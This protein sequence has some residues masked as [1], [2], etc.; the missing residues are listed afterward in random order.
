MK[1]RH[2][3]VISFYLLVSYKTSAQSTREL[4]GYP[5]LIFNTVFSDDVFHSKKTYSYLNSG[6]K[7]GYEYN[8]YRVRHL[9]LLLLDTLY[10]KNSKVYVKKNNEYWLQFDYE[11]P[12]NIEITV[13]P[14]N[15][16]ENIT[17]KIVS[18]VDTIIDG[19][20]RRKVI[21][22]REDILPDGTWIEGIGP[23]SKNDVFYLPSNLWTNEY[24]TI[25]CVM[26]NQTVIYNREGFYKCDQYCD[27]PLSRFEYELDS[28]IIRIVNTSYDATKYFW[29]FSDGQKSE[30]ISPTLAIQKKCHQ[31]T[32]KTLNHCKDTSI[33]TIKIPVCIDPD[34][35]EDIALPKNY[36]E[37]NIYFKDSLN[38][39]YFTDTLFRTKDGG[40]TWTK[41]IIF[42]N[43]V[44]QKN[45]IKGMS[46]SDASHGIVILTYQQSAN[47]PSLI[48]TQDGGS[49]W[50]EANMNINYLSHPT[51]LASGVWIVQNSSNL[52]YTE[53]FGISW[54]EI[55]IPNAFY[56]PNYR[57]HN[58]NLY[59][60]GYGIYPQG[61]KKYYLIKSKDIGLS[62][63]S[64]TNSPS[65]IT[66][67]HVKDNSDLIFS[68]VDYVIKSNSTFTSLDTLLKISGTWPFIN[69]VNDNVGWAYVSDKRYP[70]QGTIYRTADGGDSWKYENC[71]SIPINYFF[72]VDENTAY[73]KTPGKTLA[74]R[75]PE[76][77]LECRRSGMEKHINISDY[78]SF[79]V[80]DN[81]VHYSNINNE[82]VLLTLHS[83]DG[84]LLLNRYYDQDIHLDTHILSLPK[85]IYITSLRSKKGVIS[86]KFVLH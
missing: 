41:D 7:N 11:A 42:P 57:F 76:R 74:R 33:Y 37:A 28:S 45:R 15:S 47:K 63:E 40:K 5:G 34:W 1:A 58:G 8:V 17:Y 48:Y 26:N 68:T 65:L 69:F 13:R 31:V 24:S 60:F 46:F 85:G 4:Y 35:V 78:T 21:A 75:K 10:F 73:I 39:F 54:R 36:S 14:S 77:I 84:H 12:V 51:C 64:V 71:A 18:K 59:A 23:V 6:Q 52:F 86:K 66:D 81:I 62:W 30:E 72:A 16:L 29:E 80:H 56:T 2:V 79:F 3:L 44:N 25:T 83:I 53:N 55:E 19:R 32:L 70:E 27:V 20:S 50:K 82:E 43:A 49:S 38:G 9:K 61:V 67:M 22:S